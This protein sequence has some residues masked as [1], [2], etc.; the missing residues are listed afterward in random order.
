M[1]RHVGLFCGLFC[2]AA[3]VLLLPLLVATSAQAAETHLPTR[4]A[5]K[6]AEWTDPSPAANDAFGCSVAVSG[7]T[8]VVGVPNKAVNGLTGAGTAYV[9]VR[10]ASGWTRQAKLTAGDAAADDYFGLSVA[11]SGNTA[12]VGAYGKTVNGFT[13]AGAVYVFTR[14]GSTWKQQAKLTADDAAHFDDFGLSV[15][16]SGDTIVVGAGDKAANSLTDAGAAYVFTRSG[17]N[18][19]Q[20]AELIPSDAAAYDQFGWSVAISGHSVVVGAGNKTANSISASGVV[21][22]F[23]GSG[24]S[25]T[26]QTELTAAD[27]KANAAFG[28]FVALAGDTV[29][30]G[31]PTYNMGSL[32]WAGAAYV[33]VRSGATW[34]QQAKL[35]SP[36]PIAM[37]QFGSSV[38][39]S[40]ESALVGA[41]TESV[42]ALAGAGKAYLFCRSGTSWT[43]QLSLS[44]PDPAASDLFGSAVGL[45]GTTALVGADNKTVSTAAAAGA[46]YAFQLPP[47]VT[48]LAP[49]AGKHGAIVSI[50]GSDFGTKRGTSYVEFGATKATTYVSWS[51]TR[52]KCRV[53]ATTKVGTL[54]ITVTTSAG[55]SNTESFK[56]KG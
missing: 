18:W 46:A 51:N 54:N 25:W 34:S 47:T 48:K 26:Q 17:S 2:S 35:I 30:I 9:Y 14:S 16:I 21:Y 27:P 37:G 36:N 15:A 6:Y 38:A 3:L 52:I 20:K 31:A 42:G 45:A 11:V 56:V 10:S 7:T 55:T 43:R 22:V 41:S 5:L 24:S 40:G 13:I 23:T 50:T 32:G 1:K 19:S 4:L 44:A 33:F 29:V 8:A 39:V 28:R 12:V 53:P 49:A